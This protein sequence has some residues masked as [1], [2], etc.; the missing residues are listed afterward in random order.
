M[1][2]EEVFLRQR[3]ADALHNAALDLTLH[4]ARMQRAADILHCSVAQHSDDHEINI[5]LDIDDMRGEARIGAG[6]VEL[7][8][9]A[10]RAAH[11]VRLGRELGQRERRELAGIGAGRP[12][13]SI[14]P[15]HRI[16]VDLPDPRGPLLQLPDYLLGRLRDH[17][18]RGEGDAA[19]AGEVREADRGGIADQHRDTA[20]VD[21]QQLRGDIGD[22]SAAAADI[23]MPGRHRDVAVLGDVHLRAALP[24]GIEPEA[25]SD[26]A[27]ALHA[28]ARVLIERCLV[29]RVLEGSFDRL[30]E[31]D[32][33]EGRPIDGLLAFPGAVLQPDFQRIEAQL[34][35]DLVDHAFRREGTERGARGPISR[36]LRAVGDDIIPGRED[37]RDV[38]GREGA[39]DRTTQRRSGQGTRLQV[40]SALCGDQRAVLLGADLDRAQRAGSRASGAHHLLAR[41]HHLHRPSA[42]LR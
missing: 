21:A 9:G 26:A 20:V 18:R 3:P 17:H 6:G 7:G 2:V 22:R 19:A 15:G 24:A 37:V 10:E 39:A 5:D 25:G 31:G 4:V 40:E 41:H 35:A 1:F 33:A 27:A 36:D 28:R 32:L 23:R 12:R 34:L 13:L 16:R 14:L 29:V 42:L 38:V 8:A 30:L 11:L